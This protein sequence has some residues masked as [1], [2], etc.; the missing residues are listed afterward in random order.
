MLELASHLER[1]ATQL[2]REGFWRIKIALAGTDTSSLLE[3]LEGS[4]G[5]VDLDT[6]TSSVS[7]EITEA[8]TTKS[9]TTEKSLQTPLGET[10]EKASVPLSEDSS[11][12]TAELVFPLKSIPLV[13]AKLPEPFMPL[14]G[15]ETLSCYRCQYPSCDHEFSQKAAACNHVHH[16]HLNIALACLYCSFDDNPKMCWYSASAWEHHSCRYTQDNLPIYPDDP[17]FSQQFIHVPWDEVTSSTSKSPFEL[18][19][20]KII[21]QSA[22]AAKQFLEE[23]SGSTFHY[24]SI[25]EL[26]PNHQEVSK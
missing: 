21:Q 17:A 20:S 13:I 10:S 2:C 8:P 23:E 12:A 19:H 5:Q 11:L 9:T 22:K 1:K 25:E 4:F 16:D 24:P 6:T 26:K 7:T 18:P 3:I 14:H 15:P